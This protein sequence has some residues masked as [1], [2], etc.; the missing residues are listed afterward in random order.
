MYGTG[1][2][3]WMDARMHVCMDAR[4]YACMGMRA[5]LDSGCLGRPQHNNLT[6]T[7]SEPICHRWQWAHSEVGPW[8]L[9]IAEP[10]GVKLPQTSLV[11]NAASEAAY[12]I[13]EE[14][15]RLRL[16]VLESEQ[17]YITSDS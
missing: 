4:M 3:R 7:S 5:E 15:F 13:T 9:K 16:F 6:D 14:P 11:T 1:M 12:F 8:S 10:R 17:G 2:D